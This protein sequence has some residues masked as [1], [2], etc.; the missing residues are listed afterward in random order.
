MFHRLAR[1]LEERRVWGRR[2]LYLDTAGQSALKP[3]ALMLAMASTE[4]YCGFE[5]THPV[6]AAAVG[7]ST[8]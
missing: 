3:S 7:V 1:P 4:F 5:A 2:S 6:A 8:W